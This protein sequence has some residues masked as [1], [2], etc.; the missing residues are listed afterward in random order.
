M[1]YDL[2]MG[3]NG[4]RP[5]VAI[6]RQSAKIRGY[7]LPPHVGVK[8]RASGAGKVCAAD[9]FSVIA[10]PVRSLRNAS[11]RGFRQ[12]EKISFLPKEGMTIGVVLK[13]ARCRI[14]RHA[15][16]ADHLTAVVEKSGLSE[17]TAEAD[18]VD[19]RSVL[20]EE[21]VYGGE[22]GDRIGG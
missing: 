8:R 20:P 13:K 1:A 14:C 10:D 11:D 16:S 6:T 12:V 21:R 9:N 7:A 3:V 22:A 2:G 15:R 4:H 17:C 19:H 5:A 18:Y